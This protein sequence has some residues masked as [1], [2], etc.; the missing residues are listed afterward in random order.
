[1]S[2]PTLRELM[3]R[4][5]SVRYC[6]RRL[7][8]VCG[9]GA[10][11]RDRVLDGLADDDTISARELFRKTRSIPARAFG[12]GWVVPR[13]TAELWVQALQTEL[14]LWN[15][16][17]AEARLVGRLTIVLRYHAAPLRRATGGPK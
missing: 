12:V 3:D 15:H 1:M 16:H 9:Q 6:R 4:R 2:E 10:R 5:Y 14:G 11:L 13:Q 7:G 17:S 8:R